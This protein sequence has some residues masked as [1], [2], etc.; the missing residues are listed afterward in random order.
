MSRQTSWNVNKLHF[1]QLPSYSYFN[2]NYDIT[3]YCFWNQISTF[4]WGMHQI[5]KSLADTVADIKALKIYF[6]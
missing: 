6:F 1:D 4:I 3:L 2:Y 5:I